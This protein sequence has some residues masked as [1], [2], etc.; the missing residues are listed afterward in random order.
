MA[1]G[2]VSLKGDSFLMCLDVLAQEEVRRDL[3]S[4]SEQHDRD[5]I[6]GVDRN[7]LDGAGP[8]VVSINGAVT[9]L[10][11]TEFMV[12]VTGVRAPQR[13]LTYYGHSGKVTASTD[14][15]N[16]DC[17]Y[18]KCVWGRSEEA[19]VERYLHTDIRRWLR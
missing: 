1:A 10:A 19:D 14:S 6:Y 8:S 4:P 12:R 9:S 5:R 16:R 7:L 11:M 18:C 3:A 2:C 17:W 15:P 13:V